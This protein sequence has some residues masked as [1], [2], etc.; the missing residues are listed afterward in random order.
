[1]VY[2]SIS[3]DSIE[4]WGNVREVLSETVLATEAMQAALLD[5]EF[6]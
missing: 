6:V 1:M 5:G 3:R 4:L 2:F